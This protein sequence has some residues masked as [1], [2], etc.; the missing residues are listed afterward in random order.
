MRQGRM[1]TRS[2]NTASLTRGQIATLVALFIATALV[3]LLLDRGNRLG[4][5]K[6]PLERPLLALSERFTSL[7]EGVRD[8]G[9]RFGNTKDLEAENARLQAEIERLQGAEAR[10]HELELE[11]KQ[12]LAQANF[13]VL[14]PEFKSVPARVIG[15]D[16]T[17]NEKVLVLDRGSNDGVRKGMPVVSPDFLVGMVVEVSPN[18]SKVRLI[19]DEGMQIGV[20]LQDE[21]GAGIMYGRWQQ[22]GRLTIEH[23]NRDMEVEPRD[24]IITST[25]TSGMPKGLPIGFVTSW[26]KDEL[27]DTLIVEAVPY[28]NFDGLESVSIVL[29]NP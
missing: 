10:V 23:I 25:L 27:T 12:L 18:R 17:L 5:L 19:I 14:Y 3:L 1:S 2:P 6:G 28:V 26:R 21:R 15:R 7:G 22:G 13:A 24:T 20:L 16:P 11:N 29:T 4:P 8:F 9:D